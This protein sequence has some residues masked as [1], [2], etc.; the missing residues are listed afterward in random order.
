MCQQDIYTKVYTKPGVRKIL[1][2]ILNFFTLA[3]AATPGIPNY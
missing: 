1:L 2:R 3:E